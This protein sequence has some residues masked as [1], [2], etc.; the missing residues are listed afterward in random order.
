MHIAGVE[1]SFASQLLGEQPE[2]VDA[3]IKAAATD[4][5]VNDKPFPFTPDE[6]TPE[7]VAEALESGR[8]WVAPLM[9][10]PTAEI[11]SRELISAL[12]PVITGEGA[13]A[14]LAF[15]AAYHQGQVYMITTAPGFPGSAST[16]H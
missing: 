7:L 2:G 5:A 11:R 8:R 16:V 4:G 6:I 3:R 10:N 15:H 14:R 9:E 12:G 1:V 13:L